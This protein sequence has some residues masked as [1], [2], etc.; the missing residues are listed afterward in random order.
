MGCEIHLEQNSSSV[1]CDKGGRDT[2]FTY[3]NT[4]HMLLYCELIDVLYPTHHQTHHWFLLSRCAG[5]CYWASI[6]IHYQR[7]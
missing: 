5:Q 1:V 4:M 3:E 6:K 2:P 7:A